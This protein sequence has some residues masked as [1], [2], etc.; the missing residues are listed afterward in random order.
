MSRCL[1]AALLPLSA[2]AF[3]APTAATEFLG[4]SA[5]SPP[6]DATEILGVYCPNIGHEHPPD[7]PVLHQLASISTITGAQTKIG[8]P[9]VSGATGQ[10]TGSVWGDSLYTLEQFYN[11]SVVMTRVTQR[12]TKTGE[13]IQNFPF[14]D[15][16][17]MLWTGFGQQMV[18]NELDHGDGLQAVVLAPTANLGNYNFNMTLFVTDLDGSRAGWSRKLADLGAWQLTPALAAGYNA[19]RV[20]LGQMFVTL[21][22]PYVAGELTLLVILMEDGRVLR[23]V[24]NPP[25]SVFA[26]DGNWGLFGVSGSIG[27]PG[28]YFLEQDAT[29]FELLG[30]FPELGS[31]WE[32]APP[33]IATFV[34]GPPVSSSAPEGVLYVTMVDRSDP[35][36]PRAMNTVAL[37]ALPTNQSKV[38]PH[39]V[40]NFCTM[41]GG[42]LNYTCPKL[43]SGF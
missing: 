25:V 28:L 41:A 23:Q 16:P 9:V 40:R 38:K 35:S 33:A 11:G 12:S 21:G 6:T 43:I 29:E 30:T 8:Q 4:S 22:S 42:G 19:A 5:P 13:V 18:I 37:L 15:V 31:S 10:Q 34:A 20:G 36:D 14:P 26:K 7:V 2:S 17:F 1:L 3:S 24:A 27:V 32:P 39:V